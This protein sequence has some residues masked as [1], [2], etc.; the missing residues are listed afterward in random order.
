MFYFQMAYASRILSFLGVFIESGQK[1]YSLLMCVQEAEFNA[2][3][4]MQ[5]EQG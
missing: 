3:D 1:K 2:Y 4:L 5:N